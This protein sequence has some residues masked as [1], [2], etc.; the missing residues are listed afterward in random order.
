MAKCRGCGN[1]VT[2]GFARVFGDN[3]DEIYS[4]INCGKKTEE[5]RTNGEVQ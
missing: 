3:N 2:D 4:C 5:D 1:Y